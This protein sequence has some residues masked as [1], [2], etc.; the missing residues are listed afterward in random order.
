MRIISKF[1]DYYDI[2]QQY[3]FDPLLVYVRDRKEEA[4]SCPYETGNWWWDYSEFDC[5]IIGF[6][7]KIY[8]FIILTVKDAEKKIVKKDIVHTFAEFEKKAKEY[9]FEE[10]DYDYYSRRQFDVAKDH[11]QKD[12]SR[13]EKVFYKYKSPIFV[14]NRVKYEEM[15]LNP[16]LRDYEFYRVI[17]A[18]SAYQELEMFLGNLGIKND[19]VNIDDKYRIEA[20]G[21]D[22]FSFR[23]SKGK[24]K[25]KGKKSGC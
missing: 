18:Y 3:G 7:G 1:K 8:P 16:N 4:F 9:R 15:I 22:K 2:S 12:F 6:C 10:H 11:F 19:T 14:K 21:Y 20:H 17:D 13:Y 24:K 5:G 25:R 23:A